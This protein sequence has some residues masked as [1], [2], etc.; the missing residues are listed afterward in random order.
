M[1]DFYAFDFPEMEKGNFNEQLMVKIRE[2][3]GE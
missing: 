3:L 2:E 1:F